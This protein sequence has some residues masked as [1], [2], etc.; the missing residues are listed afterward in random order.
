MANPTLVRG[1]SVGQELYCR[2]DHGGLLCVR[3]L[4]RGA[5]GTFVGDA[6]APTRDRPYWSSPSVFRRI[7]S[8]DLEGWRQYGTIND[9]GFVGFK[10]GD[11]A[12]GIKP[13]PGGKDD[14][15]VSRILSRAIGQPGEGD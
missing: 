4:D 10:S 9:S 6:I 11:D 8:A 3:V 1:V 14:A 7:T 15:G 2:Y 5:E 12:G 13:I